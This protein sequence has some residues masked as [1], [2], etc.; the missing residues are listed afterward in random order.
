VRPLHS[1]SGTS[2]KLLLSPPFLLASSSVSSFHNKLLHFFLTHT[3]ALPLLIRQRNIS[4]H[5]GV[6]KI[7]KIKNF[8]LK[9]K[10]D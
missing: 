6:K 5:G 7:K 1:L 10:T 8:E 9:E 4:I 2:A 3:Y